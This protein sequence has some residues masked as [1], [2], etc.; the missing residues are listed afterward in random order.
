MTD[1][2]GMEPVGT[3]TGLLER[4]MLHE[5]LAPDN[6]GY[7]AT[8]ALRAMRFI[9]QVIVNRTRHPE[10]F[11]RPG[12]R[13]GPDAAYALMT[14]RN[15]FL[16]FADAPNLRPTFMAV[17]TAVLTAART[18]GHRLHD[19]CLAHVRMA[20]QAATETPPAEAVRRDLYY[21]LKDT[22]DPPKAFTPVFL[23][24]SLQGNNFWG[25]TIRD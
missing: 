7:D 23:I 15:A 2:L 22:A 3:A 25:Q 8:G 14:V 12:V 20:V 1:D 9:R 13:P 21:W 19:A 17:V 16:G 10:L 6:R 11:G 5:T 4:L 18:P 24:E